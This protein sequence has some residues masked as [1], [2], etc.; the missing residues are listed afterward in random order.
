MNIE[1]ALYIHDR[2]GLRDPDRITVSFIHS[3]IHSLIHSIHPPAGELLRRHAFSTPLRLFTNDRIV[4]V[5]CFR[6]LW[7]LDY[8]SYDA[9]RRTTTV[10]TSSESESAT[11]EGGQKGHL[12][13]LTPSSMI[14]IHHPPSFPVSPIPPSPPPNG[15]RASVVIRSPRPIIGR[16]GVNS[17]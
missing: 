6:I 7:F 12:C 10:C 16:K 14:T 8:Q 9:G 2:T 1:I 11:L 4:E 3:L 15:L 17:S 5:R 13:S